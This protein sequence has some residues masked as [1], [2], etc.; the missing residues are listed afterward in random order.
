[1]VVFSSTLIVVLFIGTPN[2]QPIIM[3]D[4]TELIVEKTKVSDILEDGFVVLIRGEDIIHYEDLYIDEILSRYISYDGTESYILDPLP[5]EKSHMMYANL[6]DTR[7]TYYLMKDNKI[8]GSIIPLVSETVE[9]KDAM[10]KEYAFYP[11]TYGEDITSND[12][13][14]TLSISLND[15]N[16][17]TL[18]DTLFENIFSNSERTSTHPGVYPDYWITHNDHSIISSLKTTYRYHIRYRYNETFGHGD[19]LIHITSLQY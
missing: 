15:E 16:L 3:L 2:K 6:S 4:N 9:L 12:L 7:S 18:N 14:D 17:F 19:E 10:I 5:A 1:F 8:Y 13:K 11:T